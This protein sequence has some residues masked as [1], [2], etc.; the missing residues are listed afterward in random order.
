MKYKHALSLGLSLLFLPAC[1]QVLKLSTREVTPDFKP[2]A[3]GFYYS[4]PRTTMQV[5][6]TVQRQ[7]TIPG[8]Y[9]EYAAQLLGI[10]PVPMEKEVKWN[11]VD[12]SI[13][14]LIETDPEKLYYISF[15]S[16]SL[17]PDVLAPYTR[18][19]LILS[20]DAM[21]Q[22]GSFNQ[23]R[24]DHSTLDSLW[25][26]DLSPKSYFSEITDTLYKTVLRDSMFVRIPVIKKQVVQKTIETKAGEAAKLIMKIRKQRINLLS[27][28][29]TSITQG[30]AIEVVLKEMARLEE[31]YLSLF[32]GIHRTDRHVYSW[33]FIP[34]AEGETK[35]VCN[36]DPSTGIA[37]PEGAGSAPVTIT[38]TPENPD[39]TGIMNQ[40]VTENVLYYRI[41]AKVVAR[42]EWNGNLLVRQRVNVYQLGRTVSCQVALQKGR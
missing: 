26:T 15:S 16:S 32:I 4:L 30:E 33:V 31:Q 20:P 19:G 6:L 1:S 13:S 35:T 21:L 7:I 9:A 8:P 28:K 40:P 17:V 27:G 25:F 24:T 14:P 39:T 5:K 2:Q 36:F 42:L 41:P 10:E 18:E 22:D 12:A 11:I 38:V 34:V 29:I 37:Q 23:P 3:P